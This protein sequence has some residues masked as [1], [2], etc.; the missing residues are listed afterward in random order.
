[1]A[2]TPLSQATFDLVSETFPA[3]QHAT[4]AGLLEGYDPDYPLMTS[5]EGIRRSVVVLSSGD[6]GQLVK[7]LKE[8]EFDEREIL[9]AVQDRR[10]R[11]APP[12]QD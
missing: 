9:R 3:E 4:V 10:P 5:V 11:R 7:Y 6:V 12:A 2:R 8:A 1:M